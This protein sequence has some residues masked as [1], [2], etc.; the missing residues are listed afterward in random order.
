MF[1]VIDFAN[2]LQKGQNVK[3]Q[4]TPYYDI[5]CFIDFSVRQFLPKVLTK[6]SK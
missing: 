3:S 1:I 6:G 5:G 4:K 2:S